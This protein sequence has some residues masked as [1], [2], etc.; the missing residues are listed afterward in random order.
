M[1]YGK[2]V[3]RQIDL[4]IDNNILIPC[5][6][7][8]WRLMTEMLAEK[9]YSHLERDN[10]LPSEQKECRERS[11]ETKDQLLTGKTVL[12]LS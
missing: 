1:T 8:L 3:L 6:P 7:L 2:T 10:V 5:L 12:T 11:P 4:A 9:M